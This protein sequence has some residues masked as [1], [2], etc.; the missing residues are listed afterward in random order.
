MSKGALEY[1]LKISF[2]PFLNALCKV[3]NTCTFLLG[4][5]KPRW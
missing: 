2:V 5:R 4:Y 3:D 1:V